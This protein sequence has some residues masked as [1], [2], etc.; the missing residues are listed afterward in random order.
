MCRQH[1]A[2]GVDVDVGILALLQQLLDVVQIVAADEDTRTVARPDVHFGDFGVA[3]G[4]GVGFVQKRH[5]LHAPFAGLQHQGGKRIGILASSQLSER[6]KDELVVVAI[7]LTEAG[8][9]LQI[10]RH[11]FQAVHG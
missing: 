8:G 9:V 4:G 1:L 7:H 6:L 2:V 5:C 10:G 3:V 11:T